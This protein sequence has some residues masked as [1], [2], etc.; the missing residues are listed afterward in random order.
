MPD[1]ETAIRAG[2]AKLA[3]YFPK[4]YFAMA[5]CP[6]INIWNTDSTQTRASKVVITRS[7]FYNQT[8]VQALGLVD[9]PGLTSVTYSGSLV[10]ADVYMP[11]F[12]LSI[13]ENIITNCTFHGPGGSLIA[14]KSKG[15]IE[16]SKNY[17]FNIGH[18]RAA[19]SL[20]ATPSNTL[21]KDFDLAPQQA[22]W[23]QQVGVVSIQSKGL[24]AAGEAS[25]VKDNVFKHIFAERVAILDLDADRYENI[26]VVMTGNVYEGIFSK[27]AGVIR[28]EF[29]S[30]EAT[31]KDYLTYHNAQSQS[32]GLIEVSNEI[33]TRV[34]ADDA[35]YKLSSHSENLVA[36]LG[37]NNSFVDNLYTV[38]D[39]HKVQLYLRDSQF[40]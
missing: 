26:R 15:F 19:V 38:F 39:L 17:I 21:Y 32:L 27:G 13:S 8:N 2:N 24:A 14:H 40:T 20:P 5:Q 23:S 29:F 4:G 36:V 31:V 35:L 28:L 34:Q 18:L 22:S 11:Q 25:V 3:G 6:L 1:F 9:K 37:R 33:A 16:L 10:Q 7:K 12:N 30:S